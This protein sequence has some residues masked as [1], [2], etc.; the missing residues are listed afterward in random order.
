MLIILK[1]LHNDVKTHF[2][3]LLQM[4]VLHW[5]V[6]PFIPDTSEVDITLKKS[7]IEL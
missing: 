7:F 3:D 4:T 5:F 6:D 2:F 1:Q